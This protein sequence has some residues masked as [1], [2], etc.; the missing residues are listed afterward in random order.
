MSEIYRAHGRAKE[1]SNL[2]KEIFELV[3]TF[4]ETYLTPIANEK[5]Y[6]L[7]ER[8]VVG[9]PVVRE[10][11]CKKPESDY[12]ITIQV[13]LGDSSKDKITPLSK[14]WKYGRHWL[15]L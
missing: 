2:Q 12:R 3:N 10:W 6:K 4:V 13:S 9:A 1:L 15:C 5:G 7:R 14:P 11:E 8:E